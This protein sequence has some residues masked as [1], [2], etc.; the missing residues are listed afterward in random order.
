VRDNIATV[1]HCRVFG[2]AAWLALFR[3]KLLWSC[4]SDPHFWVRQH[5]FVVADGGFEGVFDGLFLL[6]SQ[7][8]AISFQP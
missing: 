6:S 8:L 7:L 4:V 5:G 1:P 3:K 2:G